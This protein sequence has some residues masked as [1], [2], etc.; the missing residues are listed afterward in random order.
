[1]S[2]FLPST[3]SSP[4]SKSPSATMSD[5]LCPAPAPESLCGTNWAF[6]LTVTVVL[7]VRAGAIFPSS[8]VKACRKEG[9][10]SFV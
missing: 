1:M 9:N 10:N 6:L 5:L 4:S 7:E 3:I 2:R 8:R